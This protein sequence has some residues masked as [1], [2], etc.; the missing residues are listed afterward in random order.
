VKV[1]GQGLTRVVLSYGFMESPDVPRGLECA[2]EHDKLVLPDPAALT[3]YTGH[4]T[5]IPLGRSAHMARWRESIY[6]L[7]HR[8]AQRPGAYFRIP[9]GQI[10]EIGVEFQI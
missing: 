5:I 7:M 1:L 10:M 2:R 8:N 6:A 4:E 3:Y 9:T